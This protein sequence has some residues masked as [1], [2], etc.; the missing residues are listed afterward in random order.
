MNAL[1]YLVAWAFG[2]QTTV[3]VAVILARRHDRKLRRLR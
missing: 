1:G 3:V 2:T